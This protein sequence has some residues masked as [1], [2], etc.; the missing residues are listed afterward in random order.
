M[1]LQKQ[2][3]KTIMLY[4]DRAQKL[5]NT[6]QLA[7]K[8]MAS[9]INV[10]LAK[11]EMKDSELM[12]KLVPRNDSDYHPSGAEKIEFLISTNRGQPHN[13]L[14][15]VVSGGEL[16]RISLAIQIVAAEHSKIPT[17]ILDEV[18]VG[19]GGATAEVIGQLLKKLGS[20]SQVITIT[21]LPQVASHANNHY[22]AQKQKLHSEKISTTLTLLNDEDRVEEISRMLGG[23]NITEKTRGHAHEM[24]ALAQEI[25]PELL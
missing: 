21:H 4:K 22:V 5:S 2:Y 11:L 19:I 14:H 3:E 9:E 13:Q 20:I 24:L 18:D 12:I 1:T 7:A 10:Q 6:R 25:K 15:K 16:S 8:K 17:L 23:I